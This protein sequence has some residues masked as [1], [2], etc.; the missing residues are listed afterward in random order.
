MHL[1]QFGGSKF[2]IV[3]N[4]SKIKHLLVFYKHIKA[5][6]IFQLKKIINFF[7][8]YKRFKELRTLV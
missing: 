1:G 2:V 6:I 4:F 8:T 3:E 7:Y 5:Q